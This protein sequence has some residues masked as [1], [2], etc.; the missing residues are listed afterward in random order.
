M[1]KKTHKKYVALSLVVALFICTICNSNVSKA[2]TATDAKKA[3]SYNGSV[4]KTK[5]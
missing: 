1:N 5:I 2:E 3:I 4:V